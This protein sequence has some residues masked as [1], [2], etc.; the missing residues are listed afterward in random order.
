[1]FR[2]GLAC[3]GAKSQSVDTLVWSPLTFRLRRITILSG[4]TLSAQ[5]V[6]RRMLYIFADK[7]RNQPSRWAA[8]SPRMGRP[9]GPNM[10]FLGKGVR[11][12]A[13]KCYLNSQK[14]QTPS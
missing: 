5:C 11:R 1:M 12:P 8:N 9:I 3:P 4:K 13:E 6:A 2:P 14:I 10:A 7:A